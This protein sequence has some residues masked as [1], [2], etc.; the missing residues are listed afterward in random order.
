MH[1]FNP[2]TIL[3]IISLLTALKWHFFSMTRYSL[4]WL[5]IYSTCLVNVRSPSKMLVLQ[6]NIVLK[7]KLCYADDI[8]LIIDRK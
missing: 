2:I 4:R 1:K 6:I 7:N 8:L 3:Y 5:N